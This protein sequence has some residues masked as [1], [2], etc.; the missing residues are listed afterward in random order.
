M[1]GMARRHGTTMDWFGSID[2]S[3]LQ[4]DVVAAGENIWGYNQPT[5]L[6]QPDNTPISNL[7]TKFGDNMTGTFGI[8]SWSTTSGSIYQLPSA[9]QILDVGID[10]LHAS[11]WVWIAD[12]SNVDKLAR[13]DNAEFDGQLLFIESSDGETPT[14]FDKDDGTAIADANIKTLDGN[15]F[16]FPSTKTIVMLMYSAGAERVT[17]EYGVWFM[18]TNGGT[19]SSGATTELDNLGTTSINADLLPQASKD[20]GS[21]SNKWTETHTTNF[22]LYSSEHSGAGMSLQKYARIYFGGSEYWIQLYD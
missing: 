7:L 10:A 4:T 18:V 1:A 15:D 3:N 20:L 21:S 19:G 8:S 17:G 6:T 11:R 5:T 16:V 13:I 9:T 22:Y 14:I 2:F 12:S